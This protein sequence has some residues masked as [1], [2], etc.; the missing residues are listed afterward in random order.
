[1]QDAYITSR[2]IMHASG[3]S[4]ASSTNATHQY[5]SP[6]ES[7]IL[8]HS[9]PGG[10]RDCF[11]ALCLL[12]VY[13][14]YSWVLDKGH[15]NVSGFVMNVPEETYCWQIDYLCPHQRTVHET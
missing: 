13:T 7:S 6:R 3:S 2:Q 5:M 11:L 10:E 1:M 8:P 12:S 9:S 15:F 14:E 4:I